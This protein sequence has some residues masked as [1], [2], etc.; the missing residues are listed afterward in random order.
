M[1]SFALKDADAEISDVVQ[2]AMTDPDAMQVLDHVGSCFFL[3][4]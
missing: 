2:L 1:E 4:R 3:S